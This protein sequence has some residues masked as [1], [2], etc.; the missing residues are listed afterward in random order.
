[1]SETIAWLCA[2]AGLVLGL[3]AVFVP[4]F[5]GSAV[6]LLGL[7][8][9]AGLTGFEIVTREALVL[10]TVIAAAGALGQV[11]GPALSSRALAGSAGAATGAAVGAALGTL[12][13][14]PGVAWGAALV[15][16]ILLGG[17]LSWKGVREWLRGVVGAAGGCCLSGV[18]DGV[19]V[20]GVGAVLGLADFLHLPA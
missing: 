2:S 3:G 16:A 5:P 15:G 18:I 19:A 13:P 20:L 6:A 8:A 4:G 17:S 7:V 11:L 14:I 12:V 10:A 9:F 1:V